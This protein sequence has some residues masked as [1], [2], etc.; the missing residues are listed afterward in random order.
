[1]PCKNAPIPL[2]PRLIYATIRGIAWI[3]V[4]IFYR[5]R[6]V[7]GREHLR[8][9]GPAIV[10]VNHPSTFMDVLNPGLA[11]CQEMYFLANYG[12]FRHP[13][14]NWLLRRLFCIPV[15]RAEDARPGEARDNRSAF[16][17][18]FRHLERGGVLFIAP[19]GTSWMNRFV[20]PLKTGA[21]RIALEAEARH[22]WQLG[23]KVIP[24]GLSYSAPHRFRSEV[25]ICA[26][27]PIFIAEWRTY[28]ESRPK[29][30]IRR[31]TL[32]FEAQ[33]KQLSI[34]AGDET[35]EQVLSMWEEML[36]ND[37]PLPQHQ[38]F[39]RSQRLVRTS[40]RD[41]TAVR[42]TL[43]Y[44]QVLKQLN[45]PDAVFSPRQRARRLQ[46]QMQLLLGFP[47]FALGYAFWF[48]P[49]FIPFW[50]N[51][52]LKLYIGYSATVM[53][54]TGVMVFPLYGWA[55]FWGLRQAGLH[56][57]EALVSMAA[58]TFLGLFVERC[59]EA[60]H[61]ERAFLLAARKRNSS[62]ESTLLQRAEMVRLQLL[63]FLGRK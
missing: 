23:L 1:M 6:L 14:S 62:A 12:L 24:I 52:L 33:L 37:Y 59:L 7:L 58:L 54:G 43:E 42:Q 41:A 19:E 17:A 29:E 38:A 5:R 31:L 3:S 18:S 2:L 39:E 21:A 20:R 9:D 61:L 57:A 4:R 46:R 10:L 27:Q 35:G 53:I 30:A 32:Y 51:R 40:L 15:M 48:L 28:W 50:T 36:Q 60:L 63:Q 11:I 22:G 25:V 16:E 13:V 8:F 49:C 56:A 55:V 34:H 26:G 44:C 45:L 47:L